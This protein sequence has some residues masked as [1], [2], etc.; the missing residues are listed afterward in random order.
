MLGAI[1]LPAAGICAKGGDPAFKVRV[2]ANPTAYTPTVVLVRAEAITSR[3]FGSA[4]VALEWHSGA[5]AVCRGPQEA[6]TVVL[7]F[8][9]DTP[10]GDHPGAMAYARPYE[11]VHIMVLYDRIERV[12]DG[13]IQASALLAHVM[14]HEIAHLLEGVAR[15]SQ[16][17]VMKA[18]WDAHDFSALFYKPLAFAPE[19][20]ELIQRGLRVRTADATSATPL[21]ATEREW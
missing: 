8:A 3:M 12:C 7:D 17:G 10:P 18:H 19:D 6:K 20:I 13:H 2:C 15:H 5:P 14:A 11:G 21:A 9:A 1:L 4:G 16:T